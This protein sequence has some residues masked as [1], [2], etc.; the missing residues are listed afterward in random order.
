MGDGAGAAALATL[1]ILC[2]VAVVAMA[3]N[4]LRKNYEQRGDDGGDEL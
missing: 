3:L 4:D 1:G 2:A